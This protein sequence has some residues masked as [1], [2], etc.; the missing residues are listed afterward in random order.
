[1]SAPAP[2]DRLDWLTSVLW[3]TDTGGRAIVGGDR[4]GAA[5]ESYLLVPDRR[6]ARFLVPAR[7]RRAAAA[8]VRAYNRLRDPRTRF[9]RAAL[10]AALATGIAPV[11]LRDRLT[12]V[13][14]EGGPSLLEHLRTEVFGGRD[15]VAAIG[16]G[17]PGPFRKP[18]LQLFSSRGVP[19]GF[20][21]V[22]WNEVTRELVA[23]EA[24]LLARCGQAASSSFATP[25]VLHRG[26]WND[27]ELSVAAPL[28]VGVR[29]WRPW[30]A[31]PPLDVTRAIADLA[32]GGARDET[33]AGSSYW[34]GVRERL[35]V[36]RAPERSGAR[37]A[38][39]AE[40]SLVEVADT[41]ADAI[42]SRAGDRT[43]RI[44]AWHGD[45]SPWNFARDDGR[46]VVWDW[47]HG[48][49]YAPL[50]FDVLH[51]HFQL[52]FIGD[53]RDLDVSLSES[54]AAAGPALRSLGIPDPEA[55]ASLH[56]LELVLRYEGA[57][58]AGS[59]TNPRFHGAALA[60]LR[61][62]VPR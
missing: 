49:L 1:M 4:A 37:P 44:G 19:V 27:L 18:V 7:P 36:L 10:G 57:R 24:D 41:L 56:A 26:R 43:V 14:E 12:V 13:S 54:A 46:F 59:G 51:F 42:E 16:V 2:G 3:P 32:D 61:E 15:V 48:G 38:P 6:R 25:E 62:R 35:A 29:R 31:L 23:T 33:L 60:A 53:G 34:T 11:A 58:R 55:V 21:K 9:A 5:N 17:S 52:A 45:W 40:G 50:G 22:G 8:S 47:E 20:A 39:R 30:R 28:P